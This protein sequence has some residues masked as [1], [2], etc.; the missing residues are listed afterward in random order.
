[1]RPPKGW[2]ESTSST[3]SSTMSSPITIPNYDVIDE[4]DVPP[5]LRDVI[6]LTESIDDRSWTGENTTIHT[7]HID[8]Y[9]CSLYEHRECCLLK[10]IRKINP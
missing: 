5:F 6:D 9:A 10:N 3:A 2:C 7:W 8:L 4:S 1:M